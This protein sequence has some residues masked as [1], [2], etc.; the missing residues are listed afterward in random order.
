MNNFK[1]VKTS[2]RAKLVLS[3]LSVILVC[4]LVSLWIG[5]RMISDRV[6]HQAQDQVIQD[7][8]S[9]RVIYQNHLEKIRNLVRLSAGRFFI[10]EGYHQ[11]NW[12]KLREEFDRILVQEELDFFSITD[13]NG[14][15]LYRAGHPGL[16]G[17]FQNNDFMIASVLHDRRPVAGSC[18]GSLEW[19]CRENPLLEDTIRIPLHPTPGSGFSGDTLLSRALILKAAA[20]VLSEDLELLGVLYGGVV[21]NRR[22][23]IVDQ[24]KHTVYQGETYHKKD[25]GTA[26]LFL[27]DIRIAT[28]VRLGDGTRAVGT[29][30]SS[31][32]SQRVLEEGKPW[33]ERAFVV[34]AWYFTAYEP[35]RNFFGEIVG[36]LYVGIM[37]N[38]FIRTRNDTLIFFMAMTLFGMLTAF[39]IA[40]FI[41][42]NI[43]RRIRVLVTA[44]EQIAD[45]HLNQSVP[46][47]G[48]DEI[49]RLTRQFNDMARSLREK[50]AMR[51]EFISM[52]SHELK[53]PLAAVQYNLNVVLSGMADDSPE[54]I[55]NLLK[56][57]SRRIGELI[58]LIN[59][60]LKLTHI[61]SGLF[62]KD[63]RPVQVTDILK[64]AIDLLKPSLSAYP[65]H[66]E[67]DI[68]D[69]CPP[70]LASSDLLQILFLNLISNAMKFN[71]DGGRVLV[72][73]SV[74][75]GY[76]KVMVSDTGIGIPEDSL[77]YI[78]QRFYRIQEKSGV[79]G[80][81]LGLS[82]V[83]KILELYE[84][85]IE[86][87]S[88]VD[89]GSTFV[90][91]LK[92]LASP[93]DD[94][95]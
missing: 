69:I 83:K 79:E 72:A 64:D 9:A 52:M 66:L 49:G 43:I 19:L 56:P 80:S 95:A 5:F 71:R 42:G 76:I 48:R 1:T 88:K 51:D 37:E 28:N 27:R 85:T 60:W 22:Y 46:V 94:R 30:V 50:Q 24:I 63:V 77:P 55:L 8:N 47:E 23:S 15:V 33:C 39:S 90:V 38:K 65:I 6:V 89:E 2:L 10:R 70:V 92:C 14:M 25:I 41:S 81:G 45:G 91:F 7:L 93:K 54:K 84:G 86:V 18:I 82:F 87:Q 75:Q 29:R 26:T 34:N 13:K 44:S 61:E 73:L 58:R 78:F 31:E 21:L 40:W 36:I 4:G 57:M 20:P 35:I 68:P 32:V 67:T 62:L 59:D 17:D 16:S 11:D 3:F 12:Q 53:S 74:E